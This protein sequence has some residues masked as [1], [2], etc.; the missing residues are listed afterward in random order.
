MED[1]L[2]EVARRRGEAGW[3]VCTFI[4]DGGDALG[5]FF[6]SGGVWQARGRY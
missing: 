1:G 3:L 2:E 4:I 6:E 5:Y